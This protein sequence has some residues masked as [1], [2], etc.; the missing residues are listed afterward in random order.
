MTVYERKQ[1][2]EAN[3]RAGFPSLR[4]SLRDR[5]YRAREIRHSES[6]AK[7]EKLLLDQAVKCNTRT[8]GIDPGE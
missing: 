6:E 4:E 2:S 5:E 7:Y 3:H 8:V 1:I